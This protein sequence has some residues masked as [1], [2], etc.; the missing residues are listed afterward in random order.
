[1][2]EHLKN[3]CVELVHF[4]MPITCILGYFSIVIERLELGQWKEKIVELMLDLAY[5]D[6]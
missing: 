2:Q 4:H 5:I 3:N 1:M 6:R